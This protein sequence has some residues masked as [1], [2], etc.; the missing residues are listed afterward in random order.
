MLLLVVNVVSALNI[1]EDKV[2]LSVDYQDF[3]DGDYKDYVLGQASFTVNNPDAS[4][5][6]IV[7]SASGLPSTK[8]VADTK[9]V[10]IA[11]NSTQAVSYTIKVPHDKDAGT[12][13]IGTLKVEEKGNAA[14]TDSASLEQNTAM[15]LDFDR[16]EV[17][18]KSEDGSETDKFDG[19]DEESSWDLDQ[20]VLA[21]EE[22]TFTFKYANSFN[23]KYKYGTFDDIT[24]TIDDNDDLS[25]DIDDSWDLDAL[26]ADTDDSFEISFTPDEDVDEGK[27]ELDITLVAIDE[28]NVEYKIEKT[29]TIEVDRVRD[30][31]RIVKAEF[32]PETVTTCDEEVFLTVEVTN[33]G[34]DDQKAAAVAIYNQ[35]LKINE[36]IKNLVINEFS[37]KVNTWKK[38]VTIPL[39][40]V[41]EG[42]YDFDINAYIDLDENADYERVSLN[43]GKCQVTIN[44]TTPT[45]ADDSEV[46]VTVLNQTTASNTNTPTSNQPTSS[47]TVVSTTEHSYSANDFLVGAIIIAIILVVALIIVFLVVLLK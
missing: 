16:L 6:T 36:N 11:A 15:M 27:Y 19:N 28:K 47:T 2:N 5:L 25:Q 9:E 21:G 12:E 37:D 7:V 24:L 33:Y 4:N 41:K 18:Y 44:P 23:D 8:Y 26:D 40:G 10:V 29:L 42:K 38:T 20:T 17:D 31:L 13:N 30:D 34:T 43:V 3:D 14:N 45:T 22:I 39:V 32:Q 46:I 1:V 35:A